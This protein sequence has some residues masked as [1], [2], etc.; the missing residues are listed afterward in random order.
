MLVRTIGWQTSRVMKRTNMSESNYNY[1][2]EKIEPAV[3][4]LMGVSGMKLLEARDNWLSH[5]D[6]DYIL[7]YCFA[8]QIQAHWY[9]VHDALGCL[10]AAVAGGGSTHFTIAM[11][12]ETQRTA[13]F[14]K[15]LC[16]VCPIL[17][18]EKFDMRSNFNFD[19]LKENKEVA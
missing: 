2:S 16:G 9:M 12:N 5:G 14:I 11:S 8:N 1:N 10:A 18:P 19:H 3:T 13:R 7:W 17:E 15:E 4:H 6:E